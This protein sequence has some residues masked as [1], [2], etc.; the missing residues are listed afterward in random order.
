MTEKILGMH[1]KYHT[2]FCEF[3]GWRPPIHEPML[4]LGLWLNK[5]ADPIE[6]NLKQR[7][8]LYKKVYPHNK[9]KFKCSCAYLYRQSYHQDLLWK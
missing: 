4:I 3:D 9:V 5:R 8:E 7:L 1:F 2:R 6:L